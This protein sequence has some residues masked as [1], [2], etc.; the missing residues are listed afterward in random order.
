MI[1][2]SHISVDLQT[3]GYPPIVHA[4]QGEQYSRQIKM[5]LYDGG[6]AWPV[7]GGVFVAMRYSK[8]DGTHGYYDT[9][10]DGTK[11]WTAT[12]N[13]VSIQIAPQVLTVP[14]VV[15]AQLEIINNQSILATFPLRIKVD[16]DLASPVKQSEDYVNWVAWMEDQ[17]RK[18]LQDALESGEFDGPQGE[19]GVTPAI[20]AK[21][22]V[23]ANIGTPSVTV[24]KSGTAES[25]IFTFAFKNLKGATG[26]KGATGATGATGAQGPQGDPG[27]PATLVHAEVVYQV[28]D[29]GDTV[30]TGAWTASIPAVPK[31]KYLWC[32]IT[33]TYNTGNPVISY[34]VSYMGLDGAGS[35]VS[36]NG[37]GPGPDGDIKATAAQ[38]GAIAKD[39]T[40]T[41]TA[42]IPMNNH[43]ITE[44]ATPTEGEDA[45]TKDY[46]DGKRKT[47]SATIGTS[48][49]GGSVPYTQSV[50]V[51]GLLASDMPHVTPV[52]S[53]T[54]ATALAQRE[55]WGLVSSA[56]AGADTLTF[57]CLED[58]PSTAIPI[59]IEVIR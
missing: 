50:A 33:K 59:Q 11:A 12:G 54:L 24:T 18:A 52:Y 8:P 2:S 30:P 21:A 45:A 51:A 9:L 3:P 5:T 13:T 38:L 16:R 55:A 25:P 4:V 56:E 58:K 7:P 53:N 6:V 10:P 17:L 44:L 23:D 48:W 26:E 49:T 29:S 19:T 34:G 14:G 28:G 36:F 37:I 22:T 15:E 41:V 35:V 42:D 1:L 43:R 57:I 39:G 27:T 46:V 40:T 47:F 20:T 32:R 31:G